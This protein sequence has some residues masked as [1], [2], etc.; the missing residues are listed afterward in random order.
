MSLTSTYIREI[1][2]STTEDIPKQIRD[3][4]NAPELHLPC[5]KFNQA[6][7]VTRSQFLKIARKFLSLASNL[8]KAKEF[9]KK[10][11]NAVFHPEDITFDTICKVLVMFLPPE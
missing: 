1:N 4:Y 10:A 8:P 11:K 9:V 6:T 3:L 7:F 5:I 2:I